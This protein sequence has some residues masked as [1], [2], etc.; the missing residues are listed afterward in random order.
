[1][2][3]K[4]ISMAIRSLIVLLRRLKPRLLHRKDRG[5]PTEEANNSQEFDDEEIQDFD[6]EMEEES[7][8]EN[9][10]QEEFGEEE[11]KD[12]FARWV[13]Y[14]NNFGLPIHEPL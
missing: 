8:D 2:H 5:R 13:S 12:E 11:E 4:N 7:G 10:I 1:M 14:H 9:E 3:N 6:E